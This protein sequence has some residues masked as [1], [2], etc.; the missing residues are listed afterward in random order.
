MKTKELEIDYV[1]WFP[2]LT[3]ILLTLVLSLINPDFISLY[4]IKSLLTQTSV[5]VIL[6]CGMT[7]VLLTGGIDLSIGSIVSCSG[8][9]VAVALPNYGYWAY[10]FGLL[11]GAGA[12]FFNGIIVAKGKA[13]SFIVTLA[14]GGIWL[15]LA[16]VFSQGRPVPVPTDLTYYRSWIISETLGLPNVTLITIALIVFGIFILQKTTI[17]RY[18]YAMGNGERATMLSGVNVQSVRIKVFMLNGLFAAV[19]GILLF[20]RLASGTPTVGNSYLLPVITSVVV[21]GTAIT[22]GFGGIPRTVLGA[23]IIT[24]LNNG[25]NVIGIDAFAQQIVM[26]AILIVCVTINLDRKKLLVLK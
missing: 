6:S 24:L 4:N 19:G 23:F 14:S 26:G 16:Y 2:L 3:V 13:P 20:G 10:F 5:L 25:M 12:G 18:I 9:I 8:V 17:G 11:F 1:K 7:F 21:G 15:S 22:G